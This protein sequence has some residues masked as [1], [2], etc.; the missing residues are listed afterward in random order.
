MTCLKPELEEEKL[1][2]RYF[3]AFLYDSC[4]KI[5]FMNCWYFPLCVH[6]V[7]DIVFHLFNIG[8]YI[9]YNPQGIMS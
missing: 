3:L 4:C 2:V 5:T 7:C 1:K 8:E 9:E 6:F